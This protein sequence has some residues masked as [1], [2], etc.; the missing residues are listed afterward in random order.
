MTK[1]L[2]LTFALLLTAVTGAWANEYLYFE[3][4]ETSATMKYGEDFW[5]KPYYDERADWW[6]NDSPWD[7]RE[8]IKTITVDASCQNINQENLSGLFYEFTNLKTITNIDKLNTANVLDMSRLFQGCSSLST[9]DLSG[10]NTSKVTDMSSMFYGCTSLTTLNIIGWDTSKVTNTVSMFSGCT[11]LASISFPASLTT[12]GDDA[13]QGCTDLATVT[14]YAPDCTLG[15]NA[16]NGCGNLT[17]IYVFSDLVSQYQTNWNAYAGKITAM[18][19]VASGTCGKVNPEDVTWRLEGE[20]G[21]YRL[22]ISGTGAM[23]DYDNYDDQPWNSYAGD[24]KTVVIG[25]GVTTIGNYAFNGCS[26][27]TSIEIPSSVTSIDRSAF[28]ECSNLATVTFAAGSQ[29]TSIGNYA[30]YNTNL[31][32]I[33]IPSS[34]TSI[35][36]YAFYGCSVLTSVSFADGSLLT[37]IGNYAF[38]GCTGLT[39]IEIPASVT[40]IGNG[41]FYY[42]NN[43]ATVTVDADNTVYDSRNNCNAIIEKS[44]NSLI[45]G[46]KNST[47]PS[48][49]TSIGVYAFNECSGLTSIVIPASVTSIGTFAFSGCSNL[50]TVSFAEGSQLTT[51]GESAFA[52]CSGLTSI[53]IPAGMTSIGDIAFIGCDNLATVTVYAPSCT[54]GDDA[55]MGCDYLTNIYVLSDLVVDY[56]AATNWSAYEGIITA[57]PNPNGK[58]GENVRWVLTGE[59][60]DYTLTITGTGAMADYAS[61]SEQPWDDDSSS[62]KTVVIGNGVTSIGKNAFYYYSGL[63]SIEI[64]ASVESIGMSAF[65]SCEGLTSIEIPA[66]V[67]SIGG[68]AFQGCTGLETITVYA[69]S[70]SLGSSAFDG[71]SNDLKIYVF[72]DLVD[73]YQAAWSTYAGKITAIPTVT[74]SYVDADGTLHEN[75][76]AVPLNN[77]MTTLPSGTYVVNNDVTYTS[78]VT[79]SGDVTLILV[80]GKTMSVTTTDN[81]KC[82]NADGHSL[83][84]YGQTQGTGTLSAQIQGNADYVIYIKDGTL[85]IHGGNVYATVGSTETSIAIY[86]IR[87][88]AGDAFIIDRGTVTANG[89]TGYGIQGLGGN[90]CINGGQ[91]IATGA[92]KGISVSTMISSD[93][94]VLILGGGTI[95]AS[96][97]YT[98][99]EAGGGKYAGS[100]KVADGH[101]YYDE[102]ENSYTA[103]TLTSEQI[104]A[105]AGKTL[106]P[107]TGVTLTKEGSNVSVTFDGTSTTTVNIP[108]DVEVNNVIYNRTFTANKPSTVMLPFSKAVSEIGGGTF[109]T[110]GGVQKENDKWV[111]TMNEVTGSLTAN[112]PY[113]FVPEGTSLTFTGGATLNTNGGGGKETADQGSH[114]TFKGTYEYMKWTTD[115]SDPD[116]NAEREAEIGRAYGFAGVAKTD[117]NVG[118]FVKVA[119]GAKI[120]PMGCYLLWNDTPNASRAAA[121]GAATEELPQSITVRLVGSNGEIT[122]IGEIDTKTGE[123]TFDSEAWYTLNGVR[124]SGKPTKKGLYINNGRK[125][126]VK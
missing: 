8:N 52:G 82:I 56:Q 22:I 72:S 1:K 64:P 77:A 20:A 78:T 101:I 89:N 6:I 86:L 18:T 15:S 98:A 47:I 95:T 13:F 62:I 66:S 60:P 92:S 44:T 113:L 111:A 122:A 106:R 121:R 124:L 4:S 7:G 23:A 59:S 31:T 67:T 102:D 74:T 97:F 10:W 55:F 80:D 125:V 46:F 40:S 69:P 19:P 110:F 28:S 49:V 88:N 100:I 51:I 58:C 120:R 37:T 63:T 26:N 38:Q 94:G 9:L 43:L 45:I 108:V 83:H 11:K 33:E 81:H 104:T 93:F 107:V 115:T 118:D 42:C 84:I 32:S 12:I 96:S 103:G 68:F 3:I 35:G 70:C 2:L 41:I 73:D 27:L 85:G 126:V 76:E 119:S 54:L 39:S 53:E 61:S 112:T 50:A 34:V 123:M 57:M 25:N 116:Y 90:Y 16:F 65:N 117:I 29:L 24:I 75:V 48:S 71:C 114:W 17:N 21:H 5:G 87:H 109:Y 105:I 91:V 99:S 14:V 36:E 30:F 79:L